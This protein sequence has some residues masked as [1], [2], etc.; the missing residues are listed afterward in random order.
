[1]VRGQP[2]PDAQRNAHNLQ[3]ALR[4]E[5]IDTPDLGAPAVSYMTRI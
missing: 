2:G 4:I 1:M 5:A 3:P